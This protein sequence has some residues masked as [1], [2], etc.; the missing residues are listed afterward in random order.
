MGDE[1]V[2]AAPERERGDHHRHRQGGAEERPSARDGIAA[3]SRVEGEA[4][5][6]RPQGA[7]DRLPPRR[8]RAR[9]T[10]A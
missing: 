5:A 6:R 7:E 1:R 9:P 10:R 2:Q 8:R 4:D 3:G